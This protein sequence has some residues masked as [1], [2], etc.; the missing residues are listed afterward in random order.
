MENHHIHRMFFV[1]LF[2]VPYQQG[3]DVVELWWVEMTGGQLINW[4]LGI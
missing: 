1:H 4:L 3:V 2:G